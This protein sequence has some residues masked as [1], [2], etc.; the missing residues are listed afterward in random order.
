MAEYQ[1]G[2]TWLK[3][4]W[5]G[6]LIAVTHSGGGREVTL[7]QWYQ[8]DTGLYGARFAQPGEAHPV[9]LRVPTKLTAPQVRL[10]GETGE[11]L[12]KPTVEGGY[13]YCEIANP[14]CFAL[15]VFEGPAVTLIAPEL[16]VPGQ[17][18]TLKLVV[19]QP[20]PVE[21]NVEVLLPAGWG[22]LAPIIVPAQAHFEAQV[23]V[24]VPADIFG[25]N[26]ELKAVLRRGEFE[27]TTAAHLK[28]MEP[29]TGLYSFQ[30]AEG[31]LGYVT[32]GKRA[33]LTV[34]CVNNTPLPIDATVK[35]EGG[36]AGSKQLQLAALPTSDLGN[37]ETAFGKWADGA[38]PVTP[39]VGQAVFEWDCAGVQVAPV[40][41]LRDCRRQGAV[42]K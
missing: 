12:I 19:D 20:Q 15:E 24:S 9:K 34:T 29:L 22:E 16:A 23:Q 39:Q 27:R 14:N 11:V 8:S 5:P 36:P 21:S 38:G 33:R 32:P 30:Q 7:G 6:P 28:V 42:R 25:R 37:L 31:P 18:A 1:E 35:V 13:V 10:F 3:C 40:Q 2:E 4:D 17:E 26:Y 41:S